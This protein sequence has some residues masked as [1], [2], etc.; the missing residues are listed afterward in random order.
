MGRGRSEVPGRY[1]LVGGLTTRRSDR[2]SSRRHDVAVS[3][4]PSGAAVPLSDFEVERE[5]A[6]GGMGVVY[7]ARQRSLDRTVALERI[8]A[9][10]FAGPEQIR[11]FLAEAGAAAPRHR[12]DPRDRRGGRA[13]VLHDGVRRRH[14]A[15]RGLRPGDRLGDPPRARAGIV[16]RDL[17]PSN[18]LVDRDGIGPATEPRAGQGL[19]GGELLLIVDHGQAVRLEAAPVG[20]TPRSIRSEALIG[21]LSR[22]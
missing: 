18:I 3:R 22:G 2:P 20:R 16:H 13:A 12:G 11:R 14:D 4:P 10:A 6:R 7:R 19:G 8:L 21:I 1:H 17:K 15:R 9:G 5:V